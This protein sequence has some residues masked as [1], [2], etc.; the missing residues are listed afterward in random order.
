[1]SA[2]NLERKYRKLVLRMF[3]VTLLTTPLLF[4]FVG[5]S[6]QEIHPDILRKKWK[7][8]WVGVP[9]EPE[10][11][12]GVY[13]FRKVINLNQKPASFIVHV[14]ADNRYKL[15][16]ND[17]QVSHG[18]ARADVFHYNF[19]T[20]DLGPY[21]TPGKNVISAVVWNF[22]DQRPE[23]QISYRTAF[24]LQGNTAAEEIVNTDKSWK[25]IKDESLQPIK[26]E[27]IYTFYVAGP[28]ERIDMNK[29]ISGWRLP[30]YDDQAWKKA[31]EIFAGLPKGI[32]EWTNGWMLIPVLFLQWSSLLNG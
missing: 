31:T 21:L 25:C 4:I 7:A 5:V 24:I 6:A 1:M 14:S 8:F 17:Q 26:P 12:F 13:Y 10:N 32:F 28:G 19:E 20:V 22:G 15:Y 2:A 30:S 3:I 27:L 11:G 29:Q 18:P 16:V 23:A 9:G